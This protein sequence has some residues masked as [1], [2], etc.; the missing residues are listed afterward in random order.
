MPDR[1]RREVGIERKGRPGRE[2]ASPGSPPPSTGALRTLVQGADAMPA[3]LNETLRPVADVPDVD[4]IRKLYFTFDF[5][6]EE[7][8]RLPRR[9]PLFVPLSGHEN[10]GMSNLDLRQG[11]EVEG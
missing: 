10:S 7:L 5:V 6:E 1:A 11:Q 9:S 8:A 2:Y 3:S 4:A